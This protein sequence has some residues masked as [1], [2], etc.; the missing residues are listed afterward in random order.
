MTEQSST[1]SSTEDRSGYSRVIFPE[2]KRNSLFDRLL[3]KWDGRTGQR[4]SSIRWLASRAIRFLWFRLLWH[5]LVREIARECCS[6]PRRIGT[7]YTTR[8][9]LGISFGPQQLSDPRRDAQIQACI[10]DMQRIAETHRWAN[11]LDLS[12]ALECWNRGARWAERDGSTPDSAQ[13]GR[14]S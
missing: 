10:V 6:L 13:T 9:Y 3:W 11:L 2:Q 14:D 4:L 8:I 5:P 12:L 7:I 1:R